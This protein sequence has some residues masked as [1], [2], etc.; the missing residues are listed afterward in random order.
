MEE[1]KDEVLKAE[2]AVRQLAKELARAQGIADS[3][4]E[5]GRHLNGAV[6]RLEQGLLEIQEVKEQARQAVDLARHTGEEL[7]RVTQDLSSSVIQIFTRFESQISALVQQ[8]SDEVMERLANS[9]SQM[10]ALLQQKSSELANRLA[11]SENEIRALG[12][13]KEQLRQIV[14]DQGEAIK[15][16]SKLVIFCLICL[17]GIAILVFLSLRG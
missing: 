13:Q 9:E 16:L 14:V 4:E 3:A 10:S 8:K 11:N 17:I 12:Q 6:I 15:R 2:A 1:W 5:V 7:R